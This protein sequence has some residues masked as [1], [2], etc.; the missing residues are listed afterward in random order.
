M[1]IFS[2]MNLFSK[3]LNIVVFRKV[4]NENDIT[5]C[6]FGSKLSKKIFYEFRRKQ[7]TRCRRREL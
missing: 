4:E 1:L 2:N 6:S 5:S 3:Q 7:G